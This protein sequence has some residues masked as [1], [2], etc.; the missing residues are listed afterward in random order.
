[1]FH[2]FEEISLSY[3]QDDIE[4]TNQVNVY[5]IQQVT[6]YNITSGCNC[7]T[8]ENQNVTAITI[9]VAVRSP[10]RDRSLSISIIKIFDRFNRFD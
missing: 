8:H 1:M 9:R 10:V 3:L 5:C 4:S 6:N 7:T 2:M